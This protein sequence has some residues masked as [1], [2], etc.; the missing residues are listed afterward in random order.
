MIDYKLAKQLEDAGFKQLEGMNY[1]CKHEV[2]KD[3]CSHCSVLKNEFVAYPTL[4]EL[5]EACGD[6]FN[7]LSQQGLDKKMREL[8]KK[9]CGNGGNWIA[10]GGGIYEIGESPE[11]AVAN[12]FIALNKK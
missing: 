9:I 10:W 8:Q 1:Y 4:Y 11:V 2:G 5:I 12:L 3:I 7:S 6:E